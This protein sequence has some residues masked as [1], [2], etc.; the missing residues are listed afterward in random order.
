MIATVPV[1][2]DREA[3]GAAGDLPDPGPRGA[4]CDGP[5]HEDQLAR[6]L[7]LRPRVGE[8]VRGP[9]GLVN[10][11]QFAEDRGATADDGAGRAHKDGAGGG[12]IS[13]D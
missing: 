13:T 6:V 3:P 10:V 9:G 1:R 4:W 2:R 8:A 7:P 11:A 5:A 12:W